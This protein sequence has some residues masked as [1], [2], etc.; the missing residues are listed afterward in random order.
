MSYDFL[1][2]FI[3]IGDP[4]V[5]KS[6]ILLRYTDK[7]F[8]D[9]H[10]PTIG[11][12]IGNR[13]IKIGNHNI[14]VQIWD[15]AGQESFRSI[16]RSYYRGAAGAL[17]VYDITRKETFDN[18][19]EWISNARAESGSIQIMLIGNKSDLD[20]RRAIKTEEAQQF[21]KENNLSFLETSAKDDKNVEEAFFQTSKVIYD[22]IMDGQ[23]HI[24]EELSGVRSGQ[25]PNPSFK[26]KDKEEK[27]KEKNEKNQN[28]FI[29]FSLKSIPNSPKLLQEMKIPFTISI[30]P[31]FDKNYKNNSQ[32]IYSTKYRNDSVCKC[33]KCGGIFNCFVNFLEEKKAWKCNFCGTINPTISEYFKNLESNNFN[34]QEKPELIYPVIDFVVDNQNFNFSQLI[35]SYLFLI[36]VSL[37]A[38][39]SGFLDLTTKTINEMI[40]KS[41]IDGGSKANIGIITYNSSIHFYIMNKKSQNPQ[42]IVY[43]DIEKIEIPNGG[44]FLPLEDCSEKL[45][46][47]LNSL[48]QL[49]SKDNDIESYLDRALVAVEKIMKKTGGKLIIFQH[50]IPTSPFLKMRQKINQEDIGT[51]RESIIFNPHFDGNFFRNFAVSC[52]RKKTS[53]NMF[54]FAKDYVDIA[55]LSVMPKY[56]SGK[57]FYYQKFD[58][59][60]IDHQNQFKND[61]KNLLK[62]KTG[63][64]SQIE[65][66]SSKNFEISDVFGNFA[67]YSVNL[68]YIPILSNISNLILVFNLLDEL[69]TMNF[70]YFQLVFPFINGNF[71]R[72][73]RV[74]NGRVNIITNILE[75]FS[76]IQ[77]DVIMDYFMK[78][79]ITTI[80]EDGFKNAKELLFNRCLNILKVYQKYFHPDNQLANQKIISFQIH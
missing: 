16:T 41:K 59:S 66:H 79:A 61:L 33:K 35:P 48:P 13:M 32:E 57:L 27:K 72:I 20:H 47:I 56:S 30:S 7:Y 76:S 44:L 38:I 70:A 68:I 8:R 42:V 5:G 54:I 67:T 52:A 75:A 63:W 31:F 10:E 64:D 62:E 43:P 74:I 14:K 25:G 69:K 46:Q 29:N 1:L 45:N 40:Q 71:Q 65:I 34:Y 39:N 9:S 60:N 3:V 80:F 17:L 36:D 11:V 15:T 23:I 53:I 24:D 26:M 4:G 22:R 37:N 55:T 12:E 18:L 2:K 58:S 6:C 19:K 50:E 78:R 77:V 21:A 28:Q 49:F 73:L 51:L